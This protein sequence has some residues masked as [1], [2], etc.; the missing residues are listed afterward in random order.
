M[1]STPKSGQNLHSTLSSG[2]PDHAA[3][4]PRSS[5]QETHPDIL[6]VPEPPSDCR[7]TG[8]RARQTAFYASQRKNEVST[9][10]SAK[11]VIYRDRRETP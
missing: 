6:M 10:Q 3:S 7:A 8:E 1:R 11:T 5:K 4:Q 9:D 2:K